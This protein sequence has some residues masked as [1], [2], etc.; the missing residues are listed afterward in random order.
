M[1]WDKVVLDSENIVLYMRPEFIPSVSFI[2]IQRKFI[3]ERREEAEVSRQLY[4][5]FKK[6]VEQEYPGGIVDS[7]WEDILS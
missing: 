1:L 2:V 5:N 7:D 3:E 4:N 6:Y